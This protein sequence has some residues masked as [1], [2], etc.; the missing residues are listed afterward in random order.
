MPLSIL[1][2]KQSLSELITRY[3]TSIGGSKSILLLWLSQFLQG[4]S[5]LCLLY[6]MDNFNFQIRAKIATEKLP[7]E[8]V[9]QRLIDQERLSEALKCRQFLE[10][11]AQMRVQTDLYEM[12]KNDDRLEGWNLLG[13]CLIVRCN[14][15][16]A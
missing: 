8:L 9:V 6:F 13:T 7:L 14:I 11:E 5:K 4:K 15:H 12:A 1:N 2:N 10:T 3:F 16:Q